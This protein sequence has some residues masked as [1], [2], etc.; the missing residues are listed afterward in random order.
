MT[1]YKYERYT[2][3]DTLESE[4]KA[5]FNVLSTFAGGGGSSTGYRLAG[6]K[7]LAINEFVPEAQNTY[8]ENYP[9]TLIIPGDIK[10]LTGKDFLEKIN[11]KPGELD[12]LDGSPPCSAFSMAGSV[13][14]GKGNTHADAFGKKKK[15]SDIEGVE[16]VEDLFFEF[17]R[18]ANELKPKVIIGENVVGLTMGEAKEYFHKIQNTFED[19][20]Y[21]VVADVLNASYFGVPQSRKRCFFIG[22]R[23]D[24]AEKVGINF[25]TM[26]QLYPEK[27][28]KQTTLGEAINDIVNKDQEELNLLLQ[29]LSIETAVGKTL[30]K[31]PKDPDKVLTGMDYHD[32]GHHFN[33]KR[34]SL[35]KPCPTITAM[36]NFPGVA[37]TCHPLEDRKFT[38]KE[39]K[40]IMSLPEDFKLTG[41]HQ[42]QS[43]RIGRMVPPLMMKALAESVYN[44]VLKPYKELNND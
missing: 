41:K 32:K 40:R 24:I 43:E 25:M 18:I 14:H 29:K 36:G 37:G 21:L 30:V 6:G 35:R 28:D 39:L 4:R 11:L 15:Y 33:L 42:Q 44:K 31:M 2:L 20:G 9:N 7:I 38:I 10:K 26:Y 19:I 12:L 16:D 5:L 23:E 13:S 34:C 17:L 8:R 1:M 27:N 22:V 3:K